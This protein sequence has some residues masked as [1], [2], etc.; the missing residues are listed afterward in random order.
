M[1]DPVR[2]AVAAD[3]KAW[4]LGLLIIVCYLT[5]YSDQRLADP[6]EEANF[7]TSPIAVGNHTLHKVSQ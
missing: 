1:K 4:T 6:M 7:D 2:S 3:M 5:L